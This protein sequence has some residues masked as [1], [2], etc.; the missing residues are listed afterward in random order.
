[1]QAIIIAGCG[2]LGKKVAFQL[3]HQHRCEAKNI[4]PLVS[5]P[6]SAEACQRVGLSALTVDLD[7]TL[8][9]QQIAPLSQAFS[10]TAPIIF[11]FIPPPSRGASDTRALRFIDLLSDISALQDTTP[12]AKIILISTTGVYGNCHGQWVDETTS[13]KPQTDR[14]RR[15]VDAEQQFQAYCRHQHIP[16]VILRVAGIY[17]ADRL[18]LQRLREQQPIVREE[19]SP[20]SNRIHAEDLVTVCIRAAENP[21]ITGIYNCADGHPTT[22]YD[23]FMRVARICQLPEPPVISLDEARSRLSAGMLSYMNESRRIDNRKML[24][25]FKLQLKYPSL[26]EGLCGK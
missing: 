9:A 16:L 8:T 5:S 14:A 25:D 21:L 20:S 23:Y 4:L 1:M 2:Y 26:N 15:R 17:A 6:G 19:D 12:A 13:L 7:K 22:M 11:Y 10:H 3:M 18:P 24:K